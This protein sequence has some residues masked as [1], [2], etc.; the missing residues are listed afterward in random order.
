MRH[1]VVEE[2]AGYSTLMTAPYSFVNQDLASFYKLPGSFD[3]SFKKVDLDPTQRAGLLT[4]L[5]FL[6]SHAYMRTDSPIHRGVFIIRRILC[7]PQPDPPGNADLNLPPLSGSI[8][9]TR[10][11]V[12]AH[13]SPPTCN[14]CHQRI[15]NM[16][17]AFEHYDAV[18]QYRTT[19]NGE[20]VDSS[21]SVLIG[22]Q[23]VQFSNAIE[24][25]Q[26]IS[27]LDEG[28]SCY[29]TNW[30][31]Y[32]YGRADERADRCELEALNQRL[33][34]PAYSIREFLADLTTTRGFLYRPIEETP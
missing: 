7:L 26:R 1:V 24:F 31:R 2:K 19:E 6:A 4:Q 11:Q 14:S 23:M 16:G 25:I 3:A 30:L 9:T 15:N 27:A 5:G 33:A 8:K 18:G 12:T 32:A 13:T 29:S 17:F 10:Q 28:R 21:G 22:N 34:D 20:P